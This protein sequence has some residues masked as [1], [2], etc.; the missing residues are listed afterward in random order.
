MTTLTRVL[1]NVM[2]SVYKWLSEATYVVGASADQVLTDH[3]TDLVI[4]PAYP[5]DLT[6]ITAPTLAPGGPDY[7]EGEQYFGDVAPDRLLAIQVYGFVLGRGS[8]RANRVYR[9]RLKN[10]VEQL[11]EGPASNE[12]ITLYD[13]ESGAELGSFEAVNVRGRLLPVN[14]IDV[15]VDRYRFVVDVDLA[16]V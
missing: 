11:F 2:H 9:D 15:E 10:D 4:V 1:P 3:H 6:K 13:A 5:D 8:D 16:Y 14:A 12:G 7:A